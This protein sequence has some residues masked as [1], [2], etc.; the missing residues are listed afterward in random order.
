M[1]G[2]EL[3]PVEFELRPGDVLVFYTD[4]ITDARDADERF[5]EARLRA[6]LE[7][8]RGGTAEAIADAVDSAVRRHQPHQPK[9]DRAVM[10]LRVAE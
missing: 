7:A 6:V 1:P 4:G 8:A 10:V 2:L 3:E 5:G 9:D